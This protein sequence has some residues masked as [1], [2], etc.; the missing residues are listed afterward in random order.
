MIV[1]NQPAIITNQTQIVDNQV[2][3]NVITTTQAHMLNVIRKIT[4][5]KESMKA[6]T[7]FLATLRTKAEKTDKSKKLSSPKKL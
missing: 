4:G 3:L 1:A 5:E 6:T 7:E 2:S